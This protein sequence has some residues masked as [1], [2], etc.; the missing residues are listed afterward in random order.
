MAKSSKIEDYWRQNNIEGLLKEITHNLAQ[1]MPS[2]PALA[3]FQHL[4]K[5]FPRSFKSLIDE[6][7][8]MDMNP[9]PRTSTM[10]SQSIF[11][12][13]S[14]AG[15]DTGNSSDMERRGSNQSQISGMGTIRPTAGSAFT[16]L[17]KQ[18]VSTDSCSYDIKTTDLFCSQTR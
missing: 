9:K 12:P 8:N 18:N 6:S 3:I 14:E 15:R 5:K 17:L 4:Q 2:D 10:Q 1:K 7:P 11:S 16:D 13:R